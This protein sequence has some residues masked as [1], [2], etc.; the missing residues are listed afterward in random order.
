MAHQIRVGG[1][2]GAEGDVG[3]LESGATEARKAANLRG[4]GG[5]PCVS[6]EVE[7]A[8]TERGHGARDQKPASSEIGLVTVLGHGVP[9]LVLLQVSMPRIRT[10]GFRIPARG[11]ARGRDLRIPREKQVLRVYHPI[12]FDPT[13]V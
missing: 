1:A 8:E 3:D 11:F 5:G 10:P 13:L 9:P 4:R 7:D 6:A 12:E 2:T